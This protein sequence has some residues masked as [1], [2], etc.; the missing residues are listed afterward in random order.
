LVG[1]FAL[2][3][4]LFSISIIL[5]YYQLSTEDRSFLYPL[6]CLTLL[7]TGLILFFHKT[8]IQVLLSVG[9]IALL[10]IGVNLFLIYIYPR[11]NKL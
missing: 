1:F 2:N 10:L 5:L 4:T 6:C 11:R 3:M 7:Q 8:L 9:I